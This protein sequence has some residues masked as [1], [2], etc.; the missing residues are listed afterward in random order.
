MKDDLKCKIAFFS[1][2]L[3]NTVLKHCK[4]GGIAAIYQ[5]QKSYAN[6]REHYFSK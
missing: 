2:N 4:E 3:S 5:E 6:Q 1:T